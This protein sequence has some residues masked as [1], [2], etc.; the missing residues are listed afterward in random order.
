LKQALKDL[1]MTVTLPVDIASFVQ[2]QVESGAFQSTEE[3][4]RAAVQSLEADRQRQEH[5]L[6]QMLQEAVDQIDRGEFIEVD[7]AFD[8]VETQLFGQKLSES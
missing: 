4:L 2:Y 8:E 5:R 7:E 6:R 1:N 3:V